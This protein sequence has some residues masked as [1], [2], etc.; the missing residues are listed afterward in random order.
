MRCEVGAGGFGRLEGGGFAAGA[1]GGARA[2]EGGLQLNCAPFTVAHAAGTKRTT[3]NKQ[4][5]SQENTKRT[6]LARGLARSPPKRNV[7]NAP[8][9]PPPIFPPPPP[10]KKGV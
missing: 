1:V 2:R 7:Q 10:P 5:R 3:L 8:E 4:P 6:T 9:K